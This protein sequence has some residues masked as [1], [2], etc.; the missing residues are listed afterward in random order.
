MKRLT[1]KGLSERDGRNERLLN[2]SRK[3]K[4]S[5]SNFLDAFRE[6]GSLVQMRFNWSFEG[7]QINL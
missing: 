4:V 7:M 3:G 2:V 6:V 5:W 1:V